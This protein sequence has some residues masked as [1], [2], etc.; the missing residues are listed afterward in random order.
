[1]TEVKR[2]LRFR[3]ARTGV[4]HFVLARSEAR[5]GLDPG[6]LCGRG[7]RSAV[8]LTAAMDA[9]AAGKPNPATRLIALG[10]GYV[11]FAIV[12]RAVFQVD[13]QPKNN[14]DV[15]AHLI[16]AAKTA[17]ARL[18]EGID[19]AI[20]R[21][22]PLEKQARKILAGASVHR[23][24]M[25][26]LG[27]QLDRGGSTGPMFEIPIKSTTEIGCRCNRPKTTAE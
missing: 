15:S 6:H 4:S 24:A 20:P 19:H 22:S 8:R 11:S 10:R 1:M 21:G 7:R 12:N 16:T 26:V 5:N 25:L 17:Y 3:I 23:F 13:V 27:G 18:A 2:S 9:F 14:S